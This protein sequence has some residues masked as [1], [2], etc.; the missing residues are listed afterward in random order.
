MTGSIL[1]KNV[2]LA[3][4]SGSPLRKCACLT[5]KNGRIAAVEKE[6]PAC[7][8]EKIIDG[9][10]MI[11]APGFIDAHGH[12]DISGVS[13][14]GCFSKISQ[15]ITAEICGNCGLSAF[16]V[17]PENREHL[18]ELYAGYGVEISWES[19]Q[20]YIA[21]SR[22]AG[23]LMDLIPLCGHNTLRGACRGYGGGE[24]SHDEL[25]MMKTLLDR[26]LCSGAA[27]VSFGLLYTPGIS[28]A[29][30]EIAAVMK[31]AARHGKVCAAHLRSEGDQ[32]CESA[33]E[34][35]GLSREAG[36]KH[37]HF[38]HL[39]TAGKNNFSKLDRL[40]E[41]FGEARSCG[42]EITYDR[43]PY[44]ESMTQLSVVLPGRWGRLDDVALKK[45]LALP[46]AKEVL[47]DQLREA[48]DEDYWERCRIVNCTHPAF[49]PFRGKK[50][51]AIPG[52]PAANAVEMLAFDPVETRAA[53]SVMNEENMKRILL[54]PFCVA[55]SDGNALPPDGSAGH[56]HPRSFGAIPRFVRLLLDWG[57]N[58]EKAVYKCSGQTA[59]IFGLS[60]RGYIRAG[61]VGDLVLFDPDSIDGRAD[62]SAPET[63]SEGIICVVKN[64][65]II[66]NR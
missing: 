66:F 21:Y 47:A 28:A 32:L 36:L 48:K 15:G 12:S 4:G 17:T 24:S 49:A 34:M 8:A 19:C 52:D 41:L 14:P 10:K 40:F 29:A 56:S 27:G 45:E 11:L 38:S 59:D 1:L 3:D 16:P 37:F 55:G 54:S 33:A 60:D 42:L 5:D 2:W 22:A 25:E 62:F 6:F 65:K 44:I 26:E 64:G 53:F 50:I 39:K 63:P 9:E 7:A 35:I 31:T 43:Y 23:T 51:T 18:Q 13:N 46:G 20:E 57:E 61:K 30:E 58:V